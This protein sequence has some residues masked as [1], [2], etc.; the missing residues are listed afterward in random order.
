MGEYYNGDV[1]LFDKMWVGWECDRVEFNKKNMLR[2]FFLAVSVILVFLAFEHMNIVFGFLNW[3]LGVLTPFI[4][5]GVFIFILNVPL[6]VIEKHLFRPKKGKSV[7]KIKEKARRPLALTI[8]IALLVVVIGV[9]LTIIIPEIGKSLGTIAERVPSVLQNLQNWLAE[10]S[11]KNDTVKQIVSGLSI[12]WDSLTQ[13]AVAFLKDNGTNLASSAFSMISSLISTVVNVFL[14]IVMAVYVLMRK[15]KLASDVKKL[16]YAVLPLK[17]ADFVAEVGHLTNKSFYNSITGQMIECLI[18][19][20]LT[21]LGMTIFGFPYAAL[22]GVVVAV[23]SW[24]PM[25]GITIGTAIVAILLLTVNPMQALWF[26]IF[27]ICLQQIEGNLIFPRV[28]GSK[29]GLPPIIMISAIILFSGFFGIIGLLVSGPVTYVIYTLVRRFVYLRIKQRKVPKKKYE[30]RFDEQDQYED[31]VEQLQKELD[32]EL[33]KAVDMDTENRETIRQN[34]FKRLFVRPPSGNP[35]IHYIRDV[36]TV[37]P[38]SPATAVEAPV[39][40]QT[41]D[42]EPKKREP[43]EPEPVKQEKAENRPAK[44]EKN[45]SGHDRQVTDGT[46]ADASEAPRR[47]QKPKSTQQGNGSSRRRR[48]HH[49]RSDKS[50]QNQPK[51]DNPQPRQENSQPKQS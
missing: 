50:R 11:E 51:P 44:R 45:E 35:D 17:V 39:K 19:G 23:L 21:G 46:G 12:D 7:S 4:I 6:K 31:E 37:E 13:T 49:H 16:I 29:I 34:R 41:A 40:H 10:V 9:F 28:V 20:C 47:E 25:F 38:G 2:M 14:G 18:I 48:S 43:V 5:A 24:V 3:L 1:Y 22:G 42:A 36:R 32:P 33:S 8:S 30:A 15:E 27:M 26:C